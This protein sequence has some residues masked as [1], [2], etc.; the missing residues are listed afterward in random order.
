M[1][2]GQS[3]VM[4]KSAGWLGEKVAEACG[5]DDRDAKDFGKFCKYYTAGF[6]A[7]VTL[8]AI[9]GGGIAGEAAADLMDDT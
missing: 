6:L 8:D 7:L 3:Y 9:G 4:G 5:A 1:P 2:F